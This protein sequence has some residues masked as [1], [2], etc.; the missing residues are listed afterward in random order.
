MPMRTRK[1]VL[2][3]NDEIGAWDLEMHDGRT[4]LYEGPIVRWHG[5]WYKSKNGVTSFELVD[6]IQAELFELKWKELEKHS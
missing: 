6:D 5:R 2:R 3:K 4:I 1:A